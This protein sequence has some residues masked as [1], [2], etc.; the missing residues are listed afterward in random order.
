M[1]Y[2]QELL[3]RIFYLV[4][5]FIF[6]FLLLYTFKSYFFL[7][8]LSSLYFRSINQFYF[9]E[10]SFILNSPNQ[11]IEMNLVLI[12]NF[13]LFF[14]LPFVY[15]N[16]YQFLKTSLVKKELLFLRTTLLYLGLCFY[17]FNNLLLVFV[18]PYI[19]SI[20]E[21]LNL[22]L[23]NSSY[24]NLEY[25]PNFFNYLYTL[26]STIIILNILIFLTYLYSYIVFKKITFNYYILYYKF[27]FIFYYI[28]FF[29]FLFLIFDF[30]TLLF[31]F[32]ISLTIILLRLKNLLHFIII[33]K[34]RKKITHYY[35][36]K[37][38][39]MSYK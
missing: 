9:F 18:F 27:I 11:L 6:S 19:W 30:N 13:S 3:Y 15:W 25:E 24:I 17:T 37:K 16:I 12:L 38:N 14:L 23:L 22:Y 20:F 29:T 28:I 1:F 32:I 10:T 36:T 34:E 5:S 26:Q 21:V 31:V 7:I 4:L 2:F 8:L 35:A 33:F 39:Y